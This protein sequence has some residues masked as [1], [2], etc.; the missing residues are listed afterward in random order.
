[1]PQTLLLETCSLYLQGIERKNKAMY[2]P[3]QDNGDFVIVTN[4]D[5]IKFTGKKFEIKNI[6]ST[7]VILEV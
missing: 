5:K 1:M 2:N 7:L 3:N 6:T 4:I